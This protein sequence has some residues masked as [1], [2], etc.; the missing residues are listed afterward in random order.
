MERLLKH[1]LIAVIFTGLAFTSYAQKTNKSATNVGVTVRLGDQLTVRKVA[2]VDF[3][4]ILIPVNGTDVTATMDRSGA[5]TAPGT[6]L[7]GEDLRHAGQLRIDTNLTTKFDVIYA[8]TVNLVRDGHSIPIVYTPTM[9]QEDGTP[10]AFE[11]EDNIEITADQMK[12]GYF[13]DIAG[14]IE[15]PGG[16]ASGTYTGVLDVTV[17][18]E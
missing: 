12:D 9:F 8:K 7:Y 3:G 15:I 14:S 4:G 6:T 18:W 17:M 1:V 16:S 5:V 2:D 13:V 10:I 11:G